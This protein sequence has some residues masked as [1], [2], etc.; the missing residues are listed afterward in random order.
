MLISNVNSHGITFAYSY[1]KYEYN[2]VGNAEPN[3]SLFANLN[4]TFAKTETGPTIFISLLWY[5][6]HKAFGHVWSFRN[7]LKIFDQANSVLCGFKSQNSYNWWKS[8]I[9][10]CFGFRKL[11]KYGWALRCQLKSY[12]FWIRNHYHI[13]SL[14]KPEHVL[15]YEFYV[16]NRE[17]F[18]NIYT[19]YP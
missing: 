8:N 14:R 5:G 2:S 13:C 11:R 15:I 18:R 12:S 4:F 9:Q 16:K 3:K 10:D 7:F 19:K 1:N 17:D 6:I